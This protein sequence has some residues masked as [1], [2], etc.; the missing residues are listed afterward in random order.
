MQRLLS[1]LLHHR[2][3]INYLYFSFF[4]LFVIFLS[5]FHFFTWD[6]PLQK[7]SIFFICYAVGQA[8][9]E[10]SILVFITYILKSWAPRPIY[11]L[12]ISLSF[13]FLLLHFTNFTMVRLMDATLMYVV[14]F[15]FGSG[16]DHMVAGL[17]ALNMNGTMAAIILLTFSSIPVIGLWFYCFTRWLGRRRTLNLSLMQIGAVIMAVSLALFLFDVFAKDLFLPKE[18]C[19]YQKTL[20]LGMTFLSPKKNFLELPR[21]LRPFRDENK[22]LGCLPTGTLAS[23]PNIFLF[24]V[25]TLRKDYLSYAPYLT[26]FAQENIQFEHSFANASSTY[27]SWFTIFHAD[28]PIYWASM[29]DHWKGGSIP[30]TL[31][32]KLGYDIHVYSAADLHFFN[33]DRLIFGTHRELVDQILD[34]T[35]SEYSFPKDF[36]LAHVPIC[37]EIDYLTIGPKS[38]QLE[39]IKNRYKNSIRFVDSLFGAFFE[40]LKKEGLFDNAIIAV[41]GDHGEEFF[42]EGALFHGTH[43]NSHQTAVPILLKFPS[44]DWVPQL[45]TASHINLFPS[46]LHYLTK[47][48]DLGELFDGQSIFSLKHPDTRLTAL[49]NGP[50]TPLEFTL[51]RE[52]FRMRARFAGPQKLE[53]V[54]LQGL[55]D[56]AMLLP[57]L[58][59]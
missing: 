32:K 26:Q 20:P 23:K 14:K 30:L 53:V 52:E 51:D 42:E 11:F 1:K 6:P 50:D 48:S 29:R 21:P 54:E 45:Q 17:Q 8:C 47:Q 12:F 55:L 41:T 31:L 24:I 44:K 7:V 36:P 56:P 3:E 38:P 58:E 33:M 40:H 28:L 10:T 25:E 43:L 57:F 19:K 5:L 16:R 59:H 27:L 13:V 37:K 18:Y 4:L 35:H 46:I 9:L 49:Q 22:T 39:L 15:F 34:S 2:V